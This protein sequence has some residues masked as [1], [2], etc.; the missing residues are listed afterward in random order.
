MPWHDCHSIIHQVKQVFTYYIYNLAR[1]I[2]FLDNVRCELLLYGFLCC[3]KD[4]LLVSVFGN[5]DN[6]LG[7]TVNLNG[8]LDSVLNGELLDILRPSLI[9]DGVVMS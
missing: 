5:L 8:Y 4:S 2:D 6:T 1:N 9:S 7:L 3:R